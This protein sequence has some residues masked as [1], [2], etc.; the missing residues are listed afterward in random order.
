MRVDQIAMVAPCAA[1]LLAR[2]DVV[3]ETA[4]KRLADLGKERIG[5][6]IP[7]LLTQLLHIARD[8]RVAAAEGIE[9]PLEVARHENVHRR[10]GR[11]V[12][13]TV[14]VIRAGMDEIREHVVGVGRADELAHRQT[15]LLCVPAGEDVAEVAGRHDEVELVAHCDHAAV[16]GIAVRR[17]IIDDL[18][19]QTPP[20]DGVGGGQKPAA[21]RQRAGKCLVAE[22][23]LDAGLRVVK[24]A[25]HRADRDIAAGLRDHLQALDLRHAAVGIKHED[26]RARH[27]GEAL[28]GCLSSIA[29]GGNENAHLPLLAALFQARREQVRQDLQRHVLECASRPVPELEKRGGVIE[30]VHRRNGRIV[31]LAAVGCGGEVRELLVGKLA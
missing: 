29:R 7:S 20:V 26:L 3:A 21:L 22:D 30:P 27:I 2:L 18:R 5:N 16:D 14:F 1:D 17:E 8:L 6:G 31:K 9:Q 19:Q 24:V 23:L 11:G 10:G 4:G 25:A 12:K 15:H 28:Q 13:R